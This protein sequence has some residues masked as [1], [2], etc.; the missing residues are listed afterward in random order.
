MPE[1]KPSG[2]SVDRIGSDVI[3]VLEGEHDLST[4]PDLRATVTGQVQRRARWVF[5]L[6]SATFCDCT[7]IR[8]LAYAGR[9]AAAVALVAPR[10]GQP[11]R[12]IETLDL[13][14]TLAVCETLDDA[15]PK[16]PPDDDSAER[17]ARQACRAG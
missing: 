5:D 17:D 11:R 9:N 12:L 4:E 7:V 14:A 16:P 1:W 6:S 13:S 15:L 3:L 2:I 8:W 10:G